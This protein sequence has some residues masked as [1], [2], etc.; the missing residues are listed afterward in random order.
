MSHGIQNFCLWVNETTINLAPSMTR[1][2]NLSG[3]EFAAS[4]GRSIAILL[5]QT[6]SRSRPFEGLKLPTF[7][8][9]VDIDQI[10]VVGSSMA[11]PLRRYTYIC[12]LRRLSVKIQFCSTV[13]F[14]F[15][16][17]HFVYL[18]PSLKVLYEP[19]DRYIED[20]H[21]AY[22][23]GSQAYWLRVPPLESGT[24]GRTSLNRRTRSQ[25]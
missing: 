16:H 9:I 3:N 17:Q 13:L 7:G 6:C 8:T 1:A 11:T 14:G 12:L 2:W 24:Q 23:D 18:D 15:L 19:N 20:T 21:L 5:G 4:C 25:R 22:H 10:P